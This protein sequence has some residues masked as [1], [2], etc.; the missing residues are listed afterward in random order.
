MKNVQ[1]AARMNG[2][3][4]LHIAD[5]EEDICFSESASS[6]TVNLFFHLSLTPKCV[7]L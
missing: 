3:P 6:G 2:L 1:F 7:V 4:V 5:V